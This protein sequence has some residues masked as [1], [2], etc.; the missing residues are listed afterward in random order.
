MMLAGG[1]NLFNPAFQCH[2]R[3]LKAKLR[4]N[5]PDDL[6]LRLQSLRVFAPTIQSRGRCLKTQAASYSH[7]YLSLALRGLDL[8]AP[9][10]QSHGGGLKLYPGNDPLN[11]VTSPTAALCDIPPTI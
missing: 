8:I 3:G 9:E 11:D 1:F 10:I 6:P 7:Q 4:C 5:S 2:G